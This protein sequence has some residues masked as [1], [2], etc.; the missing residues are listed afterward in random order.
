MN[1][2]NKLYFYLTRSIL[3]LHTFD[4]LY[5]YICYCFAYL[6]LLFRLVDGYI[7]KNV[8]EEWLFKLYKTLSNNIFWMEIRRKYKNVLHIY[9]HLTINPST[10]NK[11]CIYKL[12]YMIVHTIKVKLCITKCFLCILCRLVYVFHAYTVQ[13]LIMHI[14][15]F[16]HYSSLCNFP[17]FQI[18]L[19]TL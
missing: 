16:T 10:S 18:K 7:L 12:L 1:S 13:C 6:L 11:Y 19:Y 8:R 17:D 2:L 15:W 5:I 14:R 9:I 3:N 4:I